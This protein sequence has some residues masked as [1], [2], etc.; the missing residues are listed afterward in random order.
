[1]LVV[2]AA[3]LAPNAKLNCEL[4]PALVT[5]GKGAADD[6]LA[7]S[8]AP[9]S[10]FFLLDEDPTNGDAPGVALGGIVGIANVGFPSDGLFEAKA[11][12]AA[13]AGEAAAG[14]VPV[15]PVE[16]EPDGAAGEDVLVEDVES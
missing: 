6:L 5:D 3:E 16:K 7:S 9:S 1:M 15:A 14:W 10:S 8:F 2:D 13:G 12:N 11:E 4:V